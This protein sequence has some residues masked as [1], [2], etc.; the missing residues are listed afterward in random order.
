MADENIAG[1][2]AAKAPVKEPT[3]PRDALAA[4][5]KYAGKRDVIMIALDADK[6]YT[7]A[8]ADAAIEKVLKTEVK[9]A[10]NGKDDE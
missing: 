5:K 8:E 6:E 7:M 4:S 10:V 3:F 2:P 1:T 9:E